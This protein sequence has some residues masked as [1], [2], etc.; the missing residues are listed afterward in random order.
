MPGRVSVH[1]VDWLELLRALLFFLVV[2]FFVL[3]LTRVVPIVIHRILLSTTERH[4]R[5]VRFLGVRGRML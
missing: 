4:E 5:R 1:L 2:F 3:E